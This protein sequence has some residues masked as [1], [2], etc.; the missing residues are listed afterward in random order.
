MSKIR[1][2]SITVLLLAAWI[3]FGSQG[4]PATQVFEPVVVKAEP[5]LATHPRFFF[6]AG[7]I[8]NLRSKANG[9]H[10]DLWQAISGYVDRA[11]DE[12]L[13]PANAPASGGLDTYR[14]YGN[15]LVAL[16][17]ACVIGEQTN[18]CN[19]A[20]DHLLIYA[21]WDQWGENE[22]RDLGQSHMMIGNA[23]AYDWLYDQL[24]TSERE[25]V[26]Q[27]LAS[28]GAKMYEASAGERTAAWL[29][30]WRR[31]YIQNHFVVNN[32]A[33]GIVALILLEE[34]PAAD[35]WL[36]HTKAQMGLVQSLLNGM[37]D[38]TWHEGITYQSYLMVMSL[39]FLVNLRDHP[40]TNVQADLLPHTYLQNYIY[41]RVYNHFVGTDD[42]IM[43]HGNFRWSFGDPRAQGILQFVANEYD[44]AHAQW[45]ASDLIT[46]DGRNPT[47]DHAVFYVYEFFYYDPEQT[48]QAPTNLPLYRTF[49]DLEGVIW[50]TGWD[51]NDLVFGFKTGAYGGRHAYQSFTQET[52][53]WSSC[54]DGPCHFNIGHDHNDMN[55]FYLYQNGWLAQETVSV[56]LEEVNYHNT[57]RIDGEDQFRPVS[58]S[59][60]VGPD[61]VG[62]D[63]QLL[64]VVNTTQLSFLAAD[65]T[66]RYANVSGMTDVS[67][68]IAFVRPDYLV[69]VDNLA[70]A[71][72][73]DY[74]WIA[75]FADEVSID[76]N[77]IKGGA[78]SNPNIL[79][80]GIV[81]PANFTTDTDDDGEV[82]VRI[83]HSTSVD[84]MRFINVLYPTA[85]EEWGN[86][87]T[88]NLVDDRNM[89]AVTAVS[90]QDGGEDHVLIRYAGT[91]TQVSSGP[92]EFDGTVAVIRHNATG[93]LIS[94]VVHNGQ[95]LTDTDKQQTLLSRKDDTVPFE[96]TFSTDGT[97][98]TIQSFVANEIS[99]HAPNATTVIFNGQSD[100]F[101][102]TGD[103]ITFG[104]SLDERVYIP[105]ILR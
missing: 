81:S 60:K 11:L 52:G 104:K 77:W 8:P 15:K 21:G 87:P 86:R 34:E 44:N 31:S 30:W 59:A 38:G 16:A 46:T 14:T 3:I 18:V 55:T 76:S 20:K 19:L 24:S 17:F 98:V 54:P 84:D 9:S 97:T 56:G 32:S 101:T 39:P 99:L 73:H 35:T 89:V 58:Q 29:N 27:S 6:D 43:A 67:R 83:G 69:M 70:A 92:Y 96:A 72:N 26:R 13:P 1:V 62:S 51:T 100:L 85:S 63:G 42:Y 47:V 7:E 91:P 50:R 40:D 80:V 36:Q 5:S 65:A 75:H 25:T 53:I 33:L 93:D 78:D 37:A 71:S 68:H 12:D 4:A 102:R 22:I 103:T 45:L 90:H 88:V 2:R 10:A 49:S 79:G 82:Y 23:V 94:L 61:I 105:V 74:E 64:D 57:I 41:W 28:W 95:Q 66:K 48:T